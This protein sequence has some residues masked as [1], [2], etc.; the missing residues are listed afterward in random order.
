MIEQNVLD[1]GAMSSKILILLVLIV[2][3][4]NWLGES[5]SILAL[6]HRRAKT[7]LLE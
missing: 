3:D 2:R 7:M 6:L 5:D 1:R 4:P